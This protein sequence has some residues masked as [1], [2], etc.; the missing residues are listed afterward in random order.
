M[1]YKIQVIGYDAEAD[2]L[3]LLINS[4]QP[5]AAESIELDLGI[6]VRRSFVSGE[7]VGAFVRGY[8]AFAQQVQDGDRHAFPMAEQ[9]GL[10]AVVEAIVTWQREVGQ[11][12]RD[13]AAHLK[14]WPPEAQWLEAQAANT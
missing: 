13:L 4:A 9:A 5:Q 12:S 11:L 8:R 7:I 6:Y 2:E 10:R 14:Q 3:D 1:N